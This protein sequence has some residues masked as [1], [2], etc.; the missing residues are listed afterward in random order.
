MSTPDNIVWNPINF[1]VIKDTLYLRLPDGV[2]IAYP[3]R[4]GR[5]V[6]DGR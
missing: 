2:V 6:D 1:A 4:S 5:V 3:K